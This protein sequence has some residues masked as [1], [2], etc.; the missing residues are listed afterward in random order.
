MVMNIDKLF[1]VSKCVLLNEENKILILKRTNYKNDGTEN[2][3]DLPGGSVDLDENVNLS[4]R[5]EVR[6]E[7]NI[8]IEEAEVFS[9]DSGKGIP[10][11]QFIFVLFYSRKFDLK[12]GIKLS[13]EHSEFKWIPVNEIDDYKFYLKDHR[14]K[15]IKDYFK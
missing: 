8:E 9:I 15:I 4:I 10:T 5:R 6:E 14:L 12:N 2:L 7:L 3:W 13:N 11:G 1:F